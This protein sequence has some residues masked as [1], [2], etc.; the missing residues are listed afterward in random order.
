MVQPVTW[1]P[2]CSHLGLMVAEFTLGKKSIT[3]ADEGTIK[4]LT[5]GGSFPCS[6]KNLLFV[7]KNVSIQLKLYFHFQSPT[8]VGIVSKIFVHGLD[9]FF[10]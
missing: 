7:M 5:I 4:E 1:F 9:L 10:R 2:H 8:C 6:V 3:I